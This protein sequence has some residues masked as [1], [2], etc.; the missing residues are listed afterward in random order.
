ME[1]CKK[2]HALMIPKGDYNVCT[3]CNFK[4]KIIPP[5]PVVEKQSLTFEDINFSEGE[6]IDPEF[7]FE[8]PARFKRNKQD[9]LEKD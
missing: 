2:C 9:L 5:T 3:K 1:Y 6:H 7:F 8:R 4:K